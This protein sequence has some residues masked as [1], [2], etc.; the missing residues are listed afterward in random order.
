TIQ[1]VAFSPDG[2]LVAAGGGDWRGIV[3]LYET[4]TGKEVGQLGTEPAR[5]Y[6]LAFAP[7]GRTLAVACGDRPV[8]L[9]WLADSGEGSCFAGH[10]GGA[11]AVAFSPDGR[12][13]ASG[14]SDSTVLL[15]DLAGGRRE[16]LRPSR[17]DRIWQELAS[18]DAGC[19]AEAMAVLFAS[20][21][22]AAAFL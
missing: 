8:R 2:R 16:T 17:L 18:E 20:P 12:R 5:L 10:A 9:F 7:D 11:R 13:L 4:A 21:V 1:T 15:W 22:E 3:M 19:A 6:G 14:G